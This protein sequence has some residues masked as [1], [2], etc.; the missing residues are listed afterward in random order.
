[1]NQRSQ[2]RN[3]HGWERRRGAGTDLIVPNPKLKLLEQVREVMRLQIVD[4]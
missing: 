1:M 2:A 3:A 4:G